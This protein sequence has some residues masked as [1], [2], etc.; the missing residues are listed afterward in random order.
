MTNLYV[1]YTK[2]LAFLLREQGF[3]II[4]TGVNENY[5]QYNTYLFEDT[6]E[7]QAALHLLTKKN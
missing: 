6:P 3:K 1:I 7:V 5:P 2:K 4:K